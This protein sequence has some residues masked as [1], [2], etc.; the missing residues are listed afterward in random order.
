MKDAATVSTPIQAWELLFSK[1][2]LNIILKHTN[3]RTKLVRDTLTDSNSP[4]YKELTLIEFKAVLGSLYL[5]GVQ[6][7]SHVYIEELWSPQF[8]SNLYRAVMSRKRF[9]FILSCL[10]LDD[11]QARSERTKVH[12]LAPIKETSDIFIENCKNYYKPSH[13]LTVDEQLLAFRGRFKG[14]VYIPKKPDKYGIKIISA[15]DVQTSYMINAE[16]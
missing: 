1:N 13:N 15:N 4:T 6:K 2:L 7:Q 8:G 5:M 11:K 14:K 12:G 10:R 16:T 3:D 9:S